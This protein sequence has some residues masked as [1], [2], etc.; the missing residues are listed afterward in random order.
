MHSS[1]IIQTAAIMCVC[2]YIKHTFCSSSA[3]MS[4]VVHSCAFISKTKYK[5]D[6]ILTSLLAWL[7]SVDVEM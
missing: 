1:K 2:I 6:L 7:T 5:Q 4:I 3:F